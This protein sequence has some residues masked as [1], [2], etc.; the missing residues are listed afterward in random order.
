[1]LT[2]IC[3][4]KITYIITIDIKNSDYKDRDKNNTNMKTLLDMLTNLVQICNNFK[5]NN[6]NK[7]VFN[8]LLKLSI[9]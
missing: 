6:M 5:K 8:L 3:K 2:R 9:F 4:L 7:Y 1:M